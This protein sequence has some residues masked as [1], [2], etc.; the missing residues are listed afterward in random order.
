MIGSEIW[1]DWTEW[2]RCSVSCNEGLQTRGRQCRQGT[3][4]GPTTEQTVCNEA[5]CNPIMMQPEAHTNWG[6]FG[7]WNMCPG[8]SWQRL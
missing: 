7:D 6:S 4:L 3:C 5:D 1:S 2:G 8:G